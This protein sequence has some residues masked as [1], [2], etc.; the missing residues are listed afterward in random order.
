MDN[1]LEEKNQTTS[2]WKT[3]FCLETTRLKIKGA[4]H[5]HASS[6][7]SLPLTGVWVSDSETSLCGY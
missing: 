6:L 3:V 1:V 2:F 7:L 5:S 4:L